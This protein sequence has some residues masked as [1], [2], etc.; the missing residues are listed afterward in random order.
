MYSKA[1]EK[2]R[3]G[4]NIEGHGEKS[5]TVYRAVI[6]HFSVVSFFHSH[7]ASQLVVN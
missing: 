1:R 3:T 7:L 4:L 6:L 5:G 2:E